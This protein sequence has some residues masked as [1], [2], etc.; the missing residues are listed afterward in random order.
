S[1]LADLGY[2]F[3]AGAPFSVADDAVRFDP[4]VASIFVAPAGNDGNPGTALLPFRSIT[5]ALTA[6]SAGSHINVAAGFYTNGVETFPLD[7]RKPGLRIIGAGA[8]ASI[9][10]AAGVTTSKRVLQARGVV[11]DGAL[12]GL[13]FTGG[14]IPRTATRRPIQS[15]PLA[16]AST[17]C[18]RSWTSRI[19][20]FATTAPMPR[21]TATSGAAV[22]MRSI[23]PS[24]CAEPC[25][26]AMSPSPPLVQTTTAPTAAPWRRKTARSASSTAASSATMPTRRVTAVHGAAPSTSSTARV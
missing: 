5:R 10:K 26:R 6:A 11:G 23:P 24:P 16:A 19:A 2:H 12:T 15:R 17:F 22:S 7:L 8:Q 13:T 18:C 3:R 9:V 20:S 4:L 1:G 21:A 25:S 14:Y